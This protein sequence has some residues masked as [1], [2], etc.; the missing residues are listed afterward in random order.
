MDDGAVDDSDSQ[1]GPVS[2]GLVDCAMDGQ[3]ES[4]GT[5]HALPHT[6]S[7]TVIAT[8]LPQ[9]KER[10]VRNVPRRMRRRGMEEREEKEIRWFGLEDDRDE[11]RLLSKLR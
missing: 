9:V 6:N 2:V 3:C 10:K 4:R 5:C 11:V 7:S 1:C 8:G